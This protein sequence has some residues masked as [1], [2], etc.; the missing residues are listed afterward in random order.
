MFLCLVLEWNHILLK[1]GCLFYS[2][3][4]GGGKKDNEQN[5]D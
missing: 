2:F 1:Y 4:E 3:D 5:L